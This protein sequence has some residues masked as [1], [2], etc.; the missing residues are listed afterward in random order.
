[1]LN[2]LDDDDGAEPIEMDD[3]NLAK[4]VMDLSLSQDTRI[5]ALER[6]CETNGD[7]AVEL[8]SNFTGMYQFSGIS[9]LQKFLY[10]ICTHGRMSPFLRL[11]AAQSLL[12][13]EEDTFYEE[14]DEEIEDANAVERNKE[15]LVLGYKALDHVCYDLTDPTPRRV[16]AV[17]TLMES[18]AHK[19]VAN[20]YF[21]E[22]VNDQNLD[23]DYRYKII[24]SLELKDKIPDREFFT[25]KACLEFLFTEE[26]KT[27]TRILAAQNLM[28][29]GGLEDSK[30]DKI[31][32]IILLFAQD[33]SLHNDL[34][35]DATDLL[36]GLSPDKMQ[37]AAWKVLS[38]LASA[39]G[40]VRSVFDN[41]QNVHTSEIDKALTEGLKELAEIPLMEV[42]KL[43][44]T[45]EFVRSKVMEL[46]NVEQ[47]SDLEDGRCRACGKEDVAETCCTACEENWKCVVSLN[48]II[49]DR[50][51]Y[52]SLNFTLV[53]ILLRVWSFIDCNEYKET[54]ERRLIEELCDMCGTCSTGFA[55]RLV[56]VMSGFGGFNMRVSWEDQITSNFVGRL[57]AFARRIT[58]PDSIFRTE[59]LNEVIE[60][61]LTQHPSEKEKLNTYIQFEA[62]RERKAIEASEHLADANRAKSN[63]VTRLRKLQ[64]EG[65]ATDEEIDAVRLTPADCVTNEADGK[66][67]IKDLM[68]KMIDEFKSGDGADERIDTCIEEFAENV[69]NEMTIVTSDWGGRPHF[70]LFFG[71]VMLRIREEMYQEFCEHMDDCDFD[72]YMRKAFI[73]FEGAT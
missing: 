31:C 23:C 46:V 50:R 33:K 17:C 5:D 60:L 41:A 45:F 30:I 20:A 12:S 52:S 36:L 63:E 53:H 61:W 14:E 1:M 15:R 35:A 4:V 71:S 10:H 42:N 6:Y 32:D 59:K 69:L 2:F 39:Y 21:R 43:P 66:M 37:E 70:L 16:E 7:D 57:N 9:I 3:K 25:R 55:T 40:H 38:E 68:Q 29:L 72:L 19:I 26:N 58:D 34:R 49:M 8:F 22:L 64:D 56:N 51:R 24:L 13:Y 65:K 54:L 73:V 48:R 47:I 27:P 28:E 18:P 67:S 62:E 11:E 44:I